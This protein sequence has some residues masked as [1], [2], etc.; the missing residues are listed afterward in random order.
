MYRR[1]NEEQAR[2]ENP[3]TRG[4]P[5]FLAWRFKKHLRAAFTL[6]VWC[7]RHCTALLCYQHF[8]SNIGFCN[9]SE[10]VGLSG[11]LFTHMSTVSIAKFK[12]LCTVWE[13]LS[14]YIT[15]KNSVDILFKFIHI[16]PIVLIMFSVTV[17]FYTSQIRFS[18]KWKPSH[19]KFDINWEKRGRRRIWTYHI[20]SLI[21]WLNLESWIWFQCRCK[22]SVCVPLVSTLVSTVNSAGHLF[23]FQ[24]TSTCIDQ[25]RMSTWPTPSLPYCRDDSNLRGGACV[26]L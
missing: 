5:P 8:A 7:K 1:L 6:T 13:R 17:F 4:L 26:V 12:Y 11:H 16:F 24:P 25:P 20:R 3:V 14:S 22:S 15:K 10:Q 23:D 18:W 9:H 21:D 19:S 2:L